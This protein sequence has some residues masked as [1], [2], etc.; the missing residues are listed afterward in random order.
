MGH[1]EVTAPGPFAD[2]ENEVY[3]N[4]LFDVRRP[5]PFGWREVAEVA[6][7]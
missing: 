2:F 6:A 3:L 1:D 5:E 7:R 4:G